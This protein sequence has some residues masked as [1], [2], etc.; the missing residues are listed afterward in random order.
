[1]LI[2]GVRCPANAENVDGLWCSMIRDQMFP[3]G[4]LRPPTV[5]FE[6]AAEKASKELLDA[7]VLSDLS[8]LNPWIFNWLDDTSILVQCTV[9][10]L[11]A[12]N[13]FVALGSCKAMLG[14]LTMMG[15]GDA[16]ADSDLDLQCYRRDGE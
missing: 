6:V 15:L 10:W 5:S 14:K 13:K 1:M 16:L 12:D 9:G 8:V 3:L 11:D 7:S 4:P 2:F